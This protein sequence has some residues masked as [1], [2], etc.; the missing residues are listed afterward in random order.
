MVNPCDLNS[1]SFFRNLIL[2]NFAG[3]SSPYCKVDFTFSLSGTILGLTTSGMVLKTI[4]GTEVSIPAGSTQFS[5]PISLRVGARYTLSISSQP[6]TIVCLIHSGWEGVVPDGISDIR[7]ICHSTAAKRVYGQSGSYTSNGFGLSA[8]FLNTPY[9]ALADGN[10]LFVSDFGNNRVLYYSG[11]DTTASLVYGQLD[12]SSAA[13]GTST[14]EIN[15][16]RGLTKDKQ[17]LYITDADNNRALFFVGTNSIATRVYGQPDFVSAAPNQGGATASNTL[18]TPYGMTRDANGLYIVDQGNN[19]VLYYNDGSLLPSRVY[20][21]SDFLSNNTGSTATSLV[22][23]EGVSVSPEGVYIADTGNHRVLFFA[24][25]NTIATRVY[26]QPDFVSNLANNGT[27][28][29][30]TLNSP[31]AVL[32]F[33]GDL[34]IVDSFNNRVLLFSGTSRIASKVFGQNG[35]FISATSNAT[36]T[37]FFQP[38]GIS[39]DQDGIYIVDTDNHRVL[40]F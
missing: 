36:A 14:T 7:I 9:Q 40:V 4:T 27:I 16:P 32:A 39:V 23:P 1:E 11:T 25:T 24:G 3:D 15:R 33:G 26:G 35:S 30:G 19:R 22:S 13:V 5:I 6:E 34:W 2:K 38:Q 37:T 28:G 31:K 10:G 20:G 12:F 18:S 8:N 29:A 21:Q 17:G